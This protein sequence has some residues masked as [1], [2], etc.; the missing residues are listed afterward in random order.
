MHITSILSCYKLR[1]QT[2]YVW[3]MS[4]YNDTMAEKHHNV[5]FLSFFLFSPGDYPFRCTFLS[6]YRSAGRLC[7]FMAMGCNISQYVYM[8]HTDGHLYMTHSFCPK[9][10]KEHTYKLKLSGDALKDRCIHQLYCRP[11]PVWVH[12]MWQWVTPWQGRRTGMALVGRLPTEEEV[13]DG[14]AA[15]LPLL[16]LLMLLLLSLSL[17]WQRCP[18]EASITCHF[19]AKQA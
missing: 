16:L 4:G 18:E 13:S 14:G 7:Y 15:G 2:H 8:F 17:W 9:T 10:K 12:L 6:H 5:S 3:Y 11:R 1:N 19:P